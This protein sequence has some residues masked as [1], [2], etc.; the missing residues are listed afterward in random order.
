MSA[1]RLKARSPVRSGTAGK[2]RKASKGKDKG[3]G[4]GHAFGADNPYGRRQAGDGRQ[5]QR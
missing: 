2:A 1:S 3:K 5:F 4:S